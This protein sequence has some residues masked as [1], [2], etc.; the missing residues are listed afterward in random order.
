MPKKSKHK[1]KPLTSEQTCIQTLGQ[2]KIPNPL[3]FDRYVDESDSIYMEVYRDMRSLEQGKKG[4][5]EPA[6]LEHA[7]PR[8][9]LYFDPPKTKCAIVTCGGLCPGLNDVI[10]AIVME[11]VHNYNVPCVFGIRYG[12]AGFIPSCGYECIELTPES[13]ENIHKFGGTVLG[14]SRGPQ[15]TVEIVDALERMNVSILFMIGGDGTLRAA[16]KVMAEIAKRGSKISVL[17]VPKTIDNDINFVSRSFGFD[18]AVEKAV[19]AI[20]CAHTESLGAPGGIGMVKVM[21]RNAGFIAA[22]STLASRDVNYV[23][24]PEAPF[25]LHGEMGFLNVLRERIK[26]RGHAVIVLAEGAGQETFKD[27]VGKDASGNQKLGDI[28]KMLSHEIR[29]AFDADG[30]TYTLKYIDPSYIIRSV[31]ANTTDSIYCGFLG[32]HS[33]HAAM[34]G[35]T[36]MVVSKWNGRYVHIPFG[37]VTKGKK[38]ISIKSNYWQAVLES[39]GQPWSM[40]NK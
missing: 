8:K 7:G 1:F 9:H 13:V 14:S 37:L 40:R 21:G 26:A 32:S 4:A 31:P 16:S 39:T 29:T 5:K 38:C 18:T 22:E 10:R 24:V 2:A 25:E 27:I 12:L 23:L 28:G 17:G 30:P 34:S 3:N 6:M 19:E 33:V 11:C 36:G 20:R 15:D 35:R